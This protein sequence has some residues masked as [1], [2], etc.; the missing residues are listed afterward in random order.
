MYLYFKLQP[1]EIARCRNI[2]IIKSGSGRR[3]ILKESNKG[4]SAAIPYVSGCDI[5]RISAGFQIHLNKCIMAFTHISEPE[6][7]LSSSV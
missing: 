7:A 3:E 5:S 2:K 4:R 1:A 6:I